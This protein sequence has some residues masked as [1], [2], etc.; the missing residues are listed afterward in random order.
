[1]GQ[2]VGATLTTHVPRL[3]IFDEAAR[4]AYMG[5]KIST[6]YAALGRMYQERIAPLGLETFLIV[7]THWW[8]TLDYIINAHERHEGVYTSDE[9]PVMLHDYHYDYPGDRELAELIA[10]EAKEA[11]I[12]AYASA[13]RGLPIHYGTL[14]PMHYLNPRRDKRIL[15]MSILYTSSVHNDLRFGELIGR[16][17][18]KSGRRVVFVAS[19][20]LSHEFWPFDTIHQHASASAEE[21]SSSLN[22]EYDLKIIDLL[23]KGRHAEVIA[24]AEEFREK[25]S[26]EGRFAHYLMMIGA[27][28]QARFTSAGIQYGEYEAAIG[29]GQA[30]FWFDAPITPTASEQPSTTSA[31]SQL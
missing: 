3:M 5:E 21:I 1:M 23:K 22:R 4:R 6:F 25:C 16:A 11:G 30:I 9:L 15:P 27:L 24:L 13:H 14:N 19:G 26:P 29:T 20:G 7:D 8:T 17:I 31:R 2:I 10:M 18:E 12:R 28:G